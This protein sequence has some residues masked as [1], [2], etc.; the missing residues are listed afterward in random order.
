LSADSTS[1][2]SSPGRPREGRRS[3]WPWIVL[4]LALLA[5]TGF[6]ISRSAVFRL[7]DVE[8]SGHVH[9]SR[10]DV[11]HVAALGEETNVLWLDTGLVSERL[12]TNLWVASAAVSRELPGTVR[13]QIVERSPV[14][15][16][17][18]HSSWLLVSADGVVLGRS[19]ADPGLPNLAVPASGLSPGDRPVE[20][21]DPVR[22]LAAMDDWVLARVRTIRPTPRGTTVAIL[23]PGGPRV[24]LGD[25]RESARAA[26]ALAAILRWSGD[27]EIEF[28]VVDLRAASAPVAI[29]M[30]PNEAAA[31]A[32]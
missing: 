11:A 10:D 30:P 27:G 26:D 13:I 4:T 24:L 1:P 23:E 6:A 21:R 32:D 20:V 5:G 12:K 8:V 2:L 22:A 16:I 29:P 19:A 15:A 14:A 3:F 18:S 31:A 17:H 7:R 9:L 25:P 28:R